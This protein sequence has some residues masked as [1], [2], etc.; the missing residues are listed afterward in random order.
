M[1]NEFSEIQ[2]TFD[3]RET[4]EKV[5]RLLVERYLVACAQVSGPVTSCYRW[6]GKIETA[7][8]WLRGLSWEHFRKDAEEN[9]DKMDLISYAPSLAEKPVLTI[10]AS[11]DALL[12]K[13]DHI[14]RLNAAIGRFGGDRLEMRCFDTDH[15]LNDERP[16]IRD[17]VAAFFL[18]NIV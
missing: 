3:Q 5:G 2:V 1:G 4:A 13:E 6:K 15:A 12:P 18:R 9:L 8:E 14:D 7:E 11:R 17:A 16:A 10:A